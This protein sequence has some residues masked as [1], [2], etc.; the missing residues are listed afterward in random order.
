ME[1]IPEDAEIVGDTQGLSNIIRGLKNVKVGK[2]AEIT[3]QSIDAHDNLHLNRMHPM[4][5]SSSLT[6]TGTIEELYIKYPD[7]GSEL[8]DND[9]LDRR[10]EEPRGNKAQRRR[11][12]QRERR[13][14][15]R[16]EKRKEQLEEEPVPENNISTHAP[17][18]ALYA[19][20]ENKLFSHTTSK[21]HR[22][23]PNERT[24]SFFA[25]FYESDT[26][27]EDWAVVCGQRDEYARFPYHCID[28]P[29][30]RLSVLVQEVEHAM[31]NLG[32]RSFADVSVL[33][34]LV[35]S[36]ASELAFFRKHLGRVKS[37]RGTITKHLGK[38][39]FDRTEDAYKKVWYGDLVLSRVIPQL[40]TYYL[41][42]T[43]RLQSRSE[44]QSRY[45]PK[46]LRISNGVLPAIG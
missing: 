21:R 8:Y 26:R 7:E 44:V 30:S 20:D 2:A 46:G 39:G 10:D 18:Q 4:A 35:S 41:E 42:L 11:L 6:L 16:I 31:E 22:A 29:L 36:K 28:P 1:G 40:Q 24:M 43:T 25:K 23:S 12:K 45:L 19:S 13:Q 15:W 37:I 32:W 3:E 33:E 17:E 34:Q 27:P 9:L 38:H 5:H 14:R